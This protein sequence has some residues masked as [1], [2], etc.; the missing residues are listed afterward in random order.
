MAQYKGPACKLCRREGAKLFLKGE[1]CMTLKCAFERRSYP[2]GEH[3][4]SGSTRR[5][6][7]STYA[8]QLREKQKARRIYGVLERQFQAYYRKA[9]RRKGVTGENLLQLL[10][11][12][13]DNLVYRSGFAASRPQARQMIQ[14]G[15]I[16]VN[17]RRVSIS[18]YLL[19]AGDRILI[20]EQA[21]PQ[22]AEAVAARGKGTPLSWLA[23][24]REILLST[25][26][27]IPKRGDIPT[28][29]QEQLIIELYSK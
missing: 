27:E 5:V 3:G 13:L 20:H 10:E 7:V 18:S 26:V 9:S 14:H 1:R 8:V 17:D 21:R 28:P 19:K 6:K 23:V 25:V 11:R 12:R 16:L 15:K 4:E 29:I 24:D 2:P 22:V